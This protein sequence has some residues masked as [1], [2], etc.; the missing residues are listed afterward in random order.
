MVLVSME[1]KEQCAVIVSLHDDITEII[2]L[3]HSLNYT[4]LETFIQRRQSPDAESYIGRGKLEEIKSF[5]ENNERKIDVIIIDGELK[6][7]QWFVLEKEWNVNVY[8]RIRLILEIFKDRADRKEAKLQVR[9]AEFEYEKPFVKELIHRAREGEHPGLM[10]GGEY[11]VDD[12]LE[13]INKKTK[14]IRN[15]L[16]KIADNRSVQRQHR[17]SSGFYLV[18]L[19]GYTNAGKSSLLNLLSDE[20]INVEDRL[21][22]T[23]S[24]TTTR[25]ETKQNHILMN[26]NV[27]FIQRLPSWIIDAFHS[28]LEEIQQADV[29]LLVLDASDSLD[30]FIL[31]LQTSLKEL[32]ELDVTAPILII[33]NKI[34]L[35]TREELDHKLISLNYLGDTFNQRIIPISIKN[36]E[37][38]ALL[39]DRI[40]QSLPLLTRLRCLIP[41]VKEAQSFISWLHE[42]THIV[43]IS[44]SEMVDIVVDCNPKLRERIIADCLQLK[45]NAFEQQITEKE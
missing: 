12:Y 24:T 25:I 37:N 30:V 41:N 26:D 17:H 34:D 43:T 32:I 39:L 20:K 16:K 3:A 29:V 44:Y 31:K 15:S 23:L 8:D 27:G 10:A 5:L 11:Q 7:S 35:I 9:L 1:N 21:F 42:K 19:A 40:Y 18:S 28:T 45:G 13:M 36:K 33:I 14:N 38:I 6:P 4:I 22:S 2:Q